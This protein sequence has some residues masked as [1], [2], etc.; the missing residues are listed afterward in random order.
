MYRSALGQLLTAHGNAV[1]ARI[2]AVNSFFFHLLL[3][4]DPVEPHLFELATNE[5]LAG[6]QGSVRLHPDT[7]MVHLRSSPQDSLS[8][9]LPLLRAKRDQYRKF[10][11][12]KKE[13]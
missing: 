5:F 11:D 7:G 10:F 1:L 9:M 4:R 3:L 2:V 8:S 13:V 6:A 12:G